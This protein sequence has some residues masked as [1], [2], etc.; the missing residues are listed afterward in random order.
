MKGISRFVVCALMI[1]FWG[2]SVPAGQVIREQGSSRAVQVGANGRLE[3]HHDERGNRLPDFSYVGYH[4][5]ERPIPDVPV[6][7][8]LEPQ[9]GDD[10]DRIQAAI[11]MLGRREPGADG[12]RGALLLT[13]GVYHVRG[14]LAINTSGIVLRGEGSGPDGTLLVAAGFGDPQYKR[15]LITVGNEVQPAVVR[16]SRSDITDDYVPIGAHRFSVTSAQG[17]HIGDRILLHRPSTA[18]WISLI[19]CDRLQPRWTRVRDLR[20]VQEG[21]NPGLY[22]QR[23]GISHPQR[24]PKEPDE[25]WEAFKERVPL[26]SDGGQLN[27]TQQWQPGEYDFYFERVITGIDGNRITIDA[28]VVHALDKQYGGGAIFL[29]RTPGRVREVGIEHLRIFSEFAAPIAGHPFGDPKR[30]ARP[31]ENHGWNAIRLSRNTENTWV[32]NITAKYFGWSVVSAVG[33][34]ATIQDSVSLGQASRVQGGRRYPF[35]I[36]GQMNLVQRCVTYGGRHEF[37]TQARTAGPNVFVDCIGKDSRQSAGPHHRYSIG[38][39]FDNVKSERSMESRFRGNSGTGH[40][41]AGTQTVFFNCIAPDFLVGAP[42]GGISWVIG[43]AG[44]YSPDKRV[45]PA[46]LYYQQVRDRLGAAGLQYLLSRH[47]IEGRLGTFA[48]VEF[49]ESP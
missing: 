8:R 40:G 5:G 15:T 31:S 10:T 47:Q 6:V 13:R 17:Y 4:A 43:S 11:D 49:V 32:R 48:W 18:E 44:T 37:V 3:Y 22:F 21:P 45:S 23:S 26:S 14:T 9:D 29:Y 27:V 19:G 38:T 36:S 35:M 7:I 1:G 30:A 2:D 46:S 34:R 20:W 25:T 16:D 39:L 12:F 42:P 28:P 41:W 24:I 33:T